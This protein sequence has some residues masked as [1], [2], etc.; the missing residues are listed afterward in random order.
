MKS[1][2]RLGGGYV[3][4]HRPVLLTASNGKKIERIR[5]VEQSAAFGPFPEFF[6]FRVRFTIVACFCK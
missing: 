2:L 6:A 4:M 1:L 3:R 5:T